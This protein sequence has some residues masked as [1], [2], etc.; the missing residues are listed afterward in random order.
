MLALDFGTVLNG[1]AQLAG[2]DRDNLP[3]HFFKQ[4]RDLANR[5]LAIAYPSAP[6]PE[7]VRVSNLTTSV[8]NKFT[9][10]SDMGEVIE[11]Y[12]KDPLLNI[13]GLPQS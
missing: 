10:T 7:L 9:L 4:V 11:V 13:D 5:R 3:S 12:D 6:W 2:L 8:A 1:V